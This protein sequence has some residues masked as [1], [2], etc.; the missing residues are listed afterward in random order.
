MLGRTSRRSMRHG[1]EP[2]G[3]AKARCQCTNPATGAQCDQPAGPGVPFCPQHMTCPLAPLSGAEPDGVAEAKRWKHFA[4]ELAHNCYAWAMQFLKPE[5]I[6]KCKEQNGHDCRKYFPQPGAKSGNRFALDVE[7]RRSCPAVEKLM[8]DDVPGITKSSY[9]AQCPAGTSKIALV[10][11]P[12]KDYHF[13]LQTKP[14]SSPS[15]LGKYGWLHKDGSNPV[16]DFDATRRPIANPQTASRDY[17]PQGSDLNYSDFCGFYCVPRTA[18]IVLAQ[19]GGSPQAA[20]K[21]ARKTRRRR[22]GHR[23]VAVVQ[24]AGTRRRR[25]RHRR[26]TRRRLPQRA[27]RFGLA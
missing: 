24:S 26:T 21:A 23:V 7:E 8:I 2:D 20:L 15:Q 4:V 3:K 5:F 27:A 13:Y 22:Q 11:S 9:H 6:Q 12:K 17:R 1:A 18:P 19:G 25:Q 16:K 10:V 14:S